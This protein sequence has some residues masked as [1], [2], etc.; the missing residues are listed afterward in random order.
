MSE[1]CVHNSTVA[2]TR[3]PLSLRAIAYFYILLG[4]LGITETVLQLS[5]FEHFYVDIFGILAIFIGCGLL[6]WKER[7]RGWADM[8]AWLEILV[9][10]LAL[11]VSIC[12]LATGRT[13]GLKASLGP[14]QGGAGIGL[15]LGLFLASFGGWK[16]HILNRPDIVER[17][18]QESRAPFLVDARYQTSPARQPFRF[19]LG[20]LFLITTLVAF[21]LLRLTDETVLYELDHQ[22]RSTTRNGNSINSVDYGVRYPRFFSKQSYLAYAVFSRGLGDLSGGVSFHYSSVAATRAELRTPGGEIIP[23]PSKTQLYEIEGD[24]LRTSDERVTL[25]EFETFM[26]SSTEDWSLDGLLAHA[27]RMR[28]TQ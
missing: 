23:L 1:N 14:L 24:I 9:A 28:E 8:F 19:S 20:S 25:E 15:L 2:D 26:N 11:G 18:R 12:D 22:S 5:V 4:T 13:M 21:V 7:W 27:R 17:F 10:F 6:Q 16:L 3:A